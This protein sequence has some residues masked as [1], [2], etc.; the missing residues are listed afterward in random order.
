MTSPLKG[1]NELMPVVN[2]LKILYGVGAGIWVPLLASRS[3]A[4]SGVRVGVRYNIHPLPLRYTA[5]CCG[6]V[7]KSV[8]PVN[9]VNI[10]GVG[11]S[12]CAIA[13]HN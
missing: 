13:W 11:L 10:Y 4:V 2:T 12:S 7:K 8:I 9:A 1:V 3:W 5:I 6:S